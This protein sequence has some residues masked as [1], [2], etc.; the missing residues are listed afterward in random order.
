MPYPVN[1]SDI[2]PMQPGET[3][4][5]P[6]SI[7][8]YNAH[9]VFCRTTSGTYSLWV[10]RKNYNGEVKKCYGGDNIADELIAGLV[11]EEFLKSYKELL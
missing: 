10:Y 7:G 3:K 9:V 1:L 5:R 11:W 8:E 4:E 6:F 2:L